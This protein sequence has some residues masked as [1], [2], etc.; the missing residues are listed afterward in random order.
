M[1]AWFE[2]G[3]GTVAHIDFAPNKNCWNLAAW[4]YGTCY[5]CGCCAKEK[6]ERC[7]NRLRYLEGMIEEEK[8]FDRWDD[9]PELRKLQE[10]NRKANL[11]FFRRKARYYKKKLDQFEREEET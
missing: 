8:T 3:D 6:K 11:R 2:M 9:D 4:C 5:G 10:K 7:E 1:G